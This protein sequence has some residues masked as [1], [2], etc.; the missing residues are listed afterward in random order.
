MWTLR[1]LESFDPGTLALLT[2]AEI[3]RVAAGRAQLLGTRRGD[4][5]H[6]AGCAS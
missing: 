6:T 1:D 2:P 3:E 5:P 4:G